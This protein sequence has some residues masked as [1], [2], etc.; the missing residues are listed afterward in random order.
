M[1]AKRQV[2]HEQIKRKQTC[3]LLFVNV[4]MCLNSKKTSSR[5][6]KRISRK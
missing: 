6:F 5:S 4:L 1:I 3:S 2:K